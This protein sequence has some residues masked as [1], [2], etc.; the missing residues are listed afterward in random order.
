[1]SRIL[2]RAFDILQITDQLNERE[3]STFKKNKNISSWKKIENVPKELSIYLP[4]SAIDFIN[5]KKISLKKNPLRIYTY[6]SVPE[7]ED[8]E[9]YI[10][11]CS[12]K[13]YE[14]FEREYA[15][16]IGLLLSSYQMDTEEEFMELGREYDEILPILI[17][18]IYLKNNNKEKDFSIKY[19]DQIKR[20]IRLFKKIYNEYK[21]FN[22]FSCNAEIHDLS[23]HEYEN[24]QRLCEEHDEDMEKCIMNH[25][26]ELSSLDGTLQIID[27]NYSAEEYKELIEEL[28]LNSDENRSSILYQRG[29]ESYGYKRLRKEI[30]KYKKR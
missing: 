13:P 1:M 16:Y 7:Y 12:N 4:D 29:I 27:K 3:I 9:R 21:K 19:L 20:D 14:E 6:T 10:R 2:G 26:V 11:F 22:D 15:F 25:L 23:E 24:Y 5:E 30:E 28:M 8:E 17:D 18:Y